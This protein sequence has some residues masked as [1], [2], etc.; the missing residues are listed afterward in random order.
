[1]SKRFLAI[2]LIGGIVWLGCAK[3]KSEEQ[4]LAEAR[5]F[6]VQEDFENATKVYEELISRF[7]NS[8]HA[9]ENL[10]KLGLIYLN[11]KEQYEKAIA[12]Y[13]RLL[14][15]YPQ[16]SSQPQALFMIGY[17]YAN[18][19]KDFDKAKQYYNMFL[20]KYPEH[21]LLTS[22]Q[23]ELEHLGKDISE[24]DIFAGSKDAQEKTDGTTA[25]AK[26]TKK[27][28]SGTKR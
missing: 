28:G 26:E 8:P 4:L 7:P 9:D 13:E 6:E 25:A 15:K 11:Q 14:E 22:V 2:L 24:I 19:L 5:K 10:Q 27:S 20:E 16:S 21:E 3:K 12:A 23:W 18:H 1:M 17:I